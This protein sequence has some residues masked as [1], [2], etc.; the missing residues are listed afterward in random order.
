MIDPDVRPAEPGDVAQLVHLEAE[1]REALVDQR[2]GNRWLEEHPL[3]GVGWPARLASD[4]V[5]VASIDDVLV[6]YAVVVDDGPE[7]SRVDQVF[8]LPGARELGFG[9][10]MLAA[11]LA[12]AR[13][14]GASVFEGEALPGDRD[15]KN[16]YERAG[17]TARLI[18]VSTRLDR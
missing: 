16:L 13:E 11:G 5:F 3:I 4:N 18:T 17:I 15:T 7:L 6:G 12:H 1:A 8:V 10:A 14:R 9:D 2:G